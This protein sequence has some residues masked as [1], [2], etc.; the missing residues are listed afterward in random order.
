MPHSSPYL[1]SLANV[2]PAKVRWPPVHAVA[3]VGGGYQTLLPPGAHLHHWGLGFKQSSLHHIDRVERDLPYSAFRQPRLSPSM[4]L[5]RWPF[6][7]G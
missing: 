3:R 5:S 4:L 1:T 2:L 6:G 7:R